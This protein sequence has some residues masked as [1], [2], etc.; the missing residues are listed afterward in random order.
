M[1]DRLARESA[2]TLIIAP[3]LRGILTR[4]CELARPGG[5]I[6]EL[7]TGGDRAGGR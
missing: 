2:W 4:Q 5:E 1:R 6:I 7:R 3:E